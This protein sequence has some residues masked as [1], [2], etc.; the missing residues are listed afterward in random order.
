MITSYL[1]PRAGRDRSDH[2]KRVAD[3]LE[4]NAYG[5]TIDEV[6]NEIYGGNLPATSI[7]YEREEVKRSVEYC[8]KKFNGKEP[9]WIWIRTRR[10]PPNDWIYMAV[11]KMCGRNVVRIIEAAVSYESYDRYYKD[12]ETRTQTLTRMQVLDIEARKMAALMSGNGQ[13]ASAHL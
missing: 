8:N 11:A 6:I 7:D 12:W 5:L 2:A 4:N 10:R 1:T 9:G 13:A 3:T